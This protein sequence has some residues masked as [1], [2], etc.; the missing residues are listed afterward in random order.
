MA[1][2]GRMVDGIVAVAG[3]V[4]AGACCVAPSRWRARVVAVVMALGCVPWLPAAVR[5]VVA[6]VL[7]G[8]A[9]VLAAGLRRRTG[10][11]RLVDLHR[12][13]GGVLMGG[14]LLLGG[15]DADATAASLAVTGDGAAHHAGALSPHLALAAAGMA[16]LVW[17]VGAEL[18]GIR[19]RR[20]ALHGPAGATG[21]RR[22]ALF[23][24]RAGMAVMV[25]AAVSAMLA[26]MLAG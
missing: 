18:S 14:M 16:Y 26:A 4:S 7:V 15:H 20:A 2:A 1:H 11:D 12:A 23:A 22:L 21:G 13:V 24:E 25:G 17:S 8:A 19:R 6:L 9:V 3:A 5:L 10:S